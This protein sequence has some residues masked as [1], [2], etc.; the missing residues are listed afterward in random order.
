MARKFILIG[1]LVDEHDGGPITIGYGRW[2]EEPAA[3]VDP[4][5][6]WRQHAVFFNDATVAAVPGDIVHMHRGRD[7]EDRSPRGN[8]DRR[9]H[10]ASRDTAP[11]RG[12]CRRLVRGRLIGIARNQG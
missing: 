8:G 10:L 7:A 11:L 3:R 12:P 2:G 4:G 9:C 1:N 5:G 6:R